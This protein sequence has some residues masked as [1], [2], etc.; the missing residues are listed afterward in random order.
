VRGL[1]FER[2]VTE[3]CKLVAAVVHGVL[4][5]FFELSLR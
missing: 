4:S 5:F 2:G 3:P 1:E